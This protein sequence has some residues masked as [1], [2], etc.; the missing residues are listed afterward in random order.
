MAAPTA[1]DSEKFVLRLPDGMRDRIKAVADRNNRSMN[2]EIVAGLEYLYPASGPDL[3]AFAAFI[4][5]VA[6][7][8]IT[9]AYADHLA[10]TLSERAT[11]IIAEEYK[12]DKRMKVEENEI[13]P[14][15][16]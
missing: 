6:P 8:L 13:K 11:E 4:R 16:S 1:R 14:A 5:S 9:P 15:K 2:A 7:H 3:T 12:A 10:F